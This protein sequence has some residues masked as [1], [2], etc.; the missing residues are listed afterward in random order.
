MY[1]ASDTEACLWFG[2]QRVKGKVDER[3]ARKVCS[4]MR[5]MLGRLRERTILEVKHFMI[6]RFRKAIFKHWG[7]NIICMKTQTVRADKLF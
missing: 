4:H 7:V 2:C 6:S 3:K 1:V 5:E